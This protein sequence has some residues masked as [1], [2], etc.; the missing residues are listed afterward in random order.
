MMRILC[1]LFKVYCCLISH[2]PT[3]VET[4]IWKLVLRMLAYLNGQPKNLTMLQL[5]DF[6]RMHLS[7][8]YISTCLMPDD[9]TSQWG[10][11]AA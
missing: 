2:H 11:S 3:P 10:R 5:N 9:F 1:I 8:S 4:R 6:T 7:T